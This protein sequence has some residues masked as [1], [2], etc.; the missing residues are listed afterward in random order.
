MKIL[1]ISLAPVR[2]EPTRIVAY[3]TPRQPHILMGTV[4]VFFVLFFRE[5]CGLQR[6]RTFQ[7]LAGEISQDVRK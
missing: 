7:D 6:A 2:I 4:V 5:T 3:T 1:N